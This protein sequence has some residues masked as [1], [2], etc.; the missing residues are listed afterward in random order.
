MFLEK[1]EKNLKEAVHR[2]EEAY[3]AVRGGA[4]K[5]GGGDN[6]PPPGWQEIMNQSPWSYNVC[7]MKGL[8]TGEKAVSSLPAKDKTLNNISIERHKL[9]KAHGS[10][11]DT[12][13]LN[14][15]GIAR[16]PMKD[17]YRLICAIKQLNRKKMARSSSEFKGGFSLSCGS[18][19]TRSTTE[20][21]NWL[22]LHGKP[23]E[24][25][26]DVAAVGKAMGVKIKVGCANK[27]DVLARSKGEGDKNV[28]VVEGAK[29]P[30]LRKEGA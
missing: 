20:Y 8:V 4:R 14:Y 28:K 7:K 26:A 12:S 5:D 6:I 18:K 9:P 17:R 30:K 16:L 11:S 29:G 2:L 25:A 22:V 10:N 24:V 3:A 23:N 15:K 1:K 19:S 21:T 13:L 27:F